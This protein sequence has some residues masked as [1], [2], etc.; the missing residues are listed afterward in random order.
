MTVEQIQEMMDERGAELAGMFRTELS[1]AIAEMGAEV[2]HLRK[3]TLVHID[4]I[5][6]EPVFSDNNKNR[7]VLVEAV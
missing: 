2:Y 7:I 1:K 3:R 4:G 6:Y 5:D